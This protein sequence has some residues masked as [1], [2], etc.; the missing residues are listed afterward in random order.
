MTG[1]VDNDCVALHCWE[2]SMY[3]TIEDFKKE[4]EYESAATLKMLD[5][6]TD[7]S[8]GTKVVPGGRTLGFLG[9]HL[10]VCIGMAGEA[11]L[12]LQIPS[13]YIDNPP[14]GAAALRNAYA[15]C[16]SEMIQAVESNWKDANLLEEVQMYGEPWTRG[17]ALL[18]MVKHQ[19]HHRGQMTVLMRQAG[20]TVPG[21]Y[22]PAKEEWAAMGMEPQP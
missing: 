7:E 11:G 17:Y 3:R 13:E 4:W 14:A 6:L 22:G 18:A 19:T 8:L 15:R 2:V 5:R 9:W 12:P 20:L 21:A 1:Q 10:V 16:S